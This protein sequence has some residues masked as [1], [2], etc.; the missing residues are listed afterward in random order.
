M[1]EL[2]GVHNGTPQGRPVCIRVHQHA[3]SFTVSQIRPNPEV[4]AEGSA[5][6][7]GVLEPIRVQDVR[8]VDVELSVGNVGRGIQFQ[9]VDGQVRRRNDHAGAGR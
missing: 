9:E 4:A 1:R 3:E 6:I 5:I 7:E 8:N 2:Q